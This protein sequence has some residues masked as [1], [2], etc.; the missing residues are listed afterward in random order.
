MFQRPC[1]LAIWRDR[2]VVSERDAKRVQVLTLEGVPLQV[3]PVDATLFGL[4]A[5]DE[6]VWLAVVN[7]AERSRAGDP[8]H[9]VHMFQAL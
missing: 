2:L 5:N 9:R 6:C 4:C 7:A 1:G 3:L 8:E